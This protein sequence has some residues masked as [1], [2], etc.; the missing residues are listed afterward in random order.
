MPRKL[1]CECGT[2]NTCRSRLYWRK[3]RSKQAAKQA[4]IKYPIAVPVTVWECSDGREFSNE[5]DALRYELELFKK[6]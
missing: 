3:N 5:V 1:K 2:C 4:S 6:G